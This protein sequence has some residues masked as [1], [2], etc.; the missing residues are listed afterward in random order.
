VLP[1]KEKHGPSLTLFYAVNFAS[2]PLKKEF[3][4]DTLLSYIKEE[5]SDLPYLPATSQGGAYHSV[6]TCHISF[7]VLPLKK[8]HGPSLTLFYAVNFALFPLKEEF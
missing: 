1:L 2:F 8:E 3:Q 6:V 4:N 5:C 7:P